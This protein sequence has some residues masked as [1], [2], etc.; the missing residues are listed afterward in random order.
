M[1]EGLLDTSDIY[2]LTKKGGYVT[3]GR[4]NLVSL[5]AGWIV[6]W[7]GGAVPYALCINFIDGDSPVVPGNIRKYAMKNGFDLIEVSEDV[8]MTDFQMPYQSMDVPSLRWDSKKELAESLLSKMGYSVSRDSRVGI[9][10]IEDDG[11]NLSV[12]ADLMIETEKGATIFNFERLP[13]QFSDIL[14][15]RGARMLYLSEEEGKRKTVTSVLG[16]L[17]KTFVSDTYRFPYTVAGGKKVCEIS[18]RALKVENGGAPLYLVEDEID[19][20]IY[21]VLNGKWEVE[22]LRY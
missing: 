3:L 4:N 22:L 15:K 19:S 14:M 17:G 12:K 5:F 2:T 11:F 13:E 16:A 6:R 8:V 9:F 20:D 1:L 18:F 7:E 21:G 10:S